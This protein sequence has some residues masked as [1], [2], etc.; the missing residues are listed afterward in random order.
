MESNNE[1]EYTGKG[2]VVPKDVM[3]ARFHPSV[4]EV[5]NE[6]FR[7]CIKLREVVFHDGLQKIG[8]RAFWN[9]TSL[10]SITFPSTITE[11]DGYAFHYCRNLME[12]VFNEGLKK[13]GGYAFY[14]C[15]SLLSITIPSTVTEVDRNAF[16][17]CSSLGEVIL[18]DGLQK[19]G[20]WSFSECSS[21]SSIK[22]PSTV[23][24]I[25]NG[26]FYSCHNLGV[27]VL[28]EGLQKIGKYAFCNCY[29]ASLSSVTI[30]SSV[31]EVDIAAFKSCNLRE[32]VFHGVPREIGNDAFIN[33]T[34]LERF[35]FPT[36][37]TR[38]DN[39]IQTGHWEEIENEVN[40]VRGVVERSG[41]DLFMSTQTMRGG[42]NWD[43]VRNDIDKIIRVISY[44]ELKEATS[45]L[46]VA[47]W[48]FKIDESSSSRRSSG[49]SSC[50][51]AR[52]DNDPSQR[53]QC[54]IS[55]GADI[56]IPGVLHY[57]VLK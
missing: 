13:I 37:S 22:L 30:P 40:E 16:Y 31:T 2:C 3:S 8:D 43:A 11:I 47:L 1:F 19:I 6:A 26:A 12:V 9:C 57:L 50:K 32:V 54:R 10:S 49:Q 53:D 24:E 7:D 4:I 33:C 45:I 18:H 56:I 21:L 52:V 41:G 35:T 25:G 39:L 51:R 23:T 14:Y 55:C 15:T 48:K 34:S 38:L 46:E 29:C 27:V 5:E 28:N 20:T 42:R 36:I 44:Y 17:N